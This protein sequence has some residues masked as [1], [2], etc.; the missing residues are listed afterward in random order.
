LTTKTYKTGKKMAGKD[1][2][3]S[4]IDSYRKRQQMMPFLVGALA[5]LLV[6]VGVIILVLWFTS[7]NRP[8]GIALFASATPTATNT[9][10]STP[11][12][13]TDTATMTETVTI[14]PTITQTMTP[15][16]PFE[17]TVQENDTCWDI[18]A[19]NKVDIR[20]LQA[21]N[22]FAA[23]A[24][25]IKPGD[26]IWIPA[27]DQALPTET[28]IPTDTA[29]GTKITYEV[30]P[31]E[32]LAVIASR[33]NS[34]VDEIIRLTNEYRKKNKLAEIKDVN[35]INAGDTVIVPWNIVT[36]TTTKVPTSTPNPKVTLS[37][38]SQTPTK[39]APT[40][41]AATLAPTAKK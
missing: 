1:S 32:T 21:L 25:P 37:R 16:G 13:P 11:V 23:N 41:A 26:K 3:Q 12:T 40:V 4:V 17:Y 9:Y 39:L 10:T 34:T 38:V 19:K 29:K 30:K 6:A 8:G 27:P 20:V 15:T 33:F 5:I 7:S 22:Q 2:P 14:E 36:P 28:D 18:A 35:K 31:G 24:C